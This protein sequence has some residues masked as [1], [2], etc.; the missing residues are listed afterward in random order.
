MTGDWC[1]LTKGGREGGCRDRK[2]GTQHYRKGGFSLDPFLD[3]RQ[4]F[5]FCHSDSFVA[6]KDKLRE[7]SREIL[8]SAEQELR[9]TSVK[10]A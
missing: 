3:V 4:K 6:L 8:R 2:A 10:E 9:M 7:K 1:P 5:N